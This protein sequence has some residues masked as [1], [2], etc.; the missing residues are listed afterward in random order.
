M[1]TTVSKKGQITIPKASRDRLGIRPGQELA[2]EVA[3]FLIGAY[4]LTQAD[5]LLTRDAGFHRTYFDR[6]E[7]LDSSAS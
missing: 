6:L 1:K 4:A 2:V 3:D 5:R 7:V